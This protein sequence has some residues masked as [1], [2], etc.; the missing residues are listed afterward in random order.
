MSDLLKD[1]IANYIKSQGKIFVVNNLLAKVE[2]K[3]GGERFE[4]IGGY[5]GF[6]EAINDLCV[7]G[8]LNPVKNSGKNGMTPVLYA[9]YR[10]ITEKN[11]LEEV[12]KNEILSFHPA[13]KKEHYLNRIQEYENDREYIISLNN[14]LQ[15]AG[16]SKINEYRCTINERSFEIFHDEKFL[17]KKGIAMLKKLGLDIENLNCY[18]TYEA[19]FYFALKPGAEGNALIIE[20]K[21]PFMS[22]IKAMSLEGSERHNVNNINLLIYGEGN[23]ITKSFEFMQELKRDNP[24]NKVYYYG[25]LD[26][27]GID[28]YQR[29]A[30]GFAYY[31]IIPHLGLYE[32]LIDSVNR[33]PEA[34][35]VVQHNIGIFLSCFDKD[36]SGRICQILKDRKYIPQEGLSFAK[37]RF[38]I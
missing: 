32:Q 34:R 37:G 17:D 38:T 13:L 22:L 7:M 9:K 31:E 16:F 11:Q 20:N 28:I 6:S 24:V 15:H 30:K 4:A 14:Y 29:L 5:K 10:V 12:Y 27:P 25:D 1:T 21:D 33:P 3:I 19:F 23:K 2:H 18:R 36:L 8:R 35:N 26:Y